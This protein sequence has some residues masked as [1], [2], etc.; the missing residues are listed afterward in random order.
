MKKYENDC[1][2]CAV[3]AYPCIGES[4]PLRRVPHWYCDECEDECQLYVFEE[5]ELCIDCIKERL[6]KV[7][8]SGD[9]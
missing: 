1:C 6:E 8:G 5:E 3:P 7:E 4:C 2:S 9:W